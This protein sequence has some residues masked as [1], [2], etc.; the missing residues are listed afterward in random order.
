MITLHKLVH[1]YKNLTKNLTVSYSICGASQ[2]A[3]NGILEKLNNPYTSTSYTTGAQLYRSELRSPSTH[4]RPRGQM[5]L[6]LKTVLWQ[7][8]WP[9]PITQLTQQTQVNSGRSNQA[10]SRMMR[11]SDVALL[12]KLPGWLRIFMD[13]WM[14]TPI[15]CFATTGT[16]S[17]CKKCFHSWRL[18]WR[19]IIWDCFLGSKTPFH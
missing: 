14:V 9:E 3:P 8:R 11:M 15:K 16:T 5:E 6:K 12:Q 7:M 1:K 19:T 17:C 4:S 13:T 10:S 2:F 18:P